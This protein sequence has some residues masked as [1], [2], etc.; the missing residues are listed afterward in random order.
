MWCVRFLRCWLLVWMGIGLGACPT[1]ARSAV[2]V[3][4]ANSVFDHSAF[5]GSAN[6]MGWEQ[7]RFGGSTVTTF[8]PNSIRVDIAYLNY[9]TAAGQH[10]SVAP[11]GPERTS[12]N[13]YSTAGIGNSLALGN[14]TDFNGP[15]DGTAT[16]SNYSLL[17]VSFTD[18]STNLPVGVDLNSFLIGDMDRA[19]GSQW[20]DFLF[21]RGTRNG[22]LVSSTSSIPSPSPT[23]GVLTYQFAA[24]TGDPAFATASPTTLSGFVGIGS[25]LNN[26]IQGTNG[27]VIFSFAAP[28]DRVEILFFQG[29]SGSGR[30]NHAIWLDPLEFTPTDFPVPLHSLPEP[31]IWLLE[32]VVGVAG[33]ALVRRRLARRSPT[34]R[35]V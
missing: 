12:A 11:F 13:F 28:V 24:I 26:N 18:V 5:G 4:W 7:G 3:S 31:G 16:L 20:S 32:A 21:A 25:T 29:P 27:D 22:N 19:S 10:L 35:D 33:L 6:S 9:G 8:G 23:V 30:A 17:R 1:P 34:P 15:N 14:R 2:I